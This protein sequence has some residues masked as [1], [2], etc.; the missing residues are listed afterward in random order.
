MCSCFNMNWAKRQNCNQ[1]QTPKPGTRPDE[2]REGRGGGEA[3]SDTHKHK[4]DKHKHKHKHKHASALLSLRSFAY[5][6]GTHPV[7]F[8]LELAP[9]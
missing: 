5:T 9:D 1:C 2:K 3:F 7:A 4:T 6:T 8:I